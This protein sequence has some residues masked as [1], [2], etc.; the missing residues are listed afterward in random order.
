MRFA[1]SGNLLS[2]G[3]FFL[4]WTAETYVDYNAQYDIYNPYS[5][6][7]EVKSSRSHQSTHALARLTFSTTIKGSFAADRA[8][9]G[10]ALRV[11]AFISVTV[12]Y[13]AARTQEPCRRQCMWK[14]VHASSLL[15]S[16]S[17]TEIDRP[18]L[19]CSFTKV[20]LLQWL[21]IRMES[22][23]MKSSKYDTDFSS[24]TR[25]PRDAMLAR[26]M[27]SMCD[28]VSVCVSHTPVLWLNLGSR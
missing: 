28:C 20:H 16:I 23:Q 13:V 9:Q 25:L 18:I 21:S 1:L 5:I 24:F 15:A 26:Y 12:P 3:C 19:R 7:V 2:K 27:L 4:L 22:C 10:T 17:P 11:A 6:V 8:R 14:N